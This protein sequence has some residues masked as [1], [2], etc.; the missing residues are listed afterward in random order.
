MASAYRLSTSKITLSDLNT[1]QPGLASL[2]K[3]EW[4]LRK[5]WQVT[6]DPAC[7][8][9]VNWV[10]KTIWQMTHRK[11]LERWE[12]NIGN[13]E[14]TPQALWSIAKSIMKRDGPKEPT[15]VHGP[16]GITLSPE[17]EGQCDC[18][19]FRK[20]FHISWSVWQKPWA[21]GEDL[22][23]KLCLHLQMTPCWEK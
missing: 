5:L 13:C 12:I 6:Q 16:L 3:H 7:K 8:T 11:A 15:A 1:N 14:V 21:T 4:R 10:T 22:E 19:L 17:R 9:A 2:L 18:G 20:Q 23:S